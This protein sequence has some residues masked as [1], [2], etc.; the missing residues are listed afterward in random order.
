MI[1]TI[2]LAFALAIYAGTLF[3]Y[4]LPGWVRVHKLSLAVRAKGKGCDS[5]GFY[6]DCVVLDDKAYCIWG[7]KTSDARKCKTSVAT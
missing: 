2:L 7:L 6:E 4:F 5:C 1:K 3:L